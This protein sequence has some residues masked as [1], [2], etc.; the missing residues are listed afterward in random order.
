[1]KNIEAN[2]ELTYRE[3]QKKLNESFMKEFK[4]LLDKY[5]ARIVAKDEYNGYPECGEDIHVYIVGTSKGYEPF[6][7]IDLGSF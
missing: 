1:M 5:N 2:P 7:N 3:K 6:I 4:A